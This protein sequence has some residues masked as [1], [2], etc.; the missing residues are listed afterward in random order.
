MHCISGHIVKKSDQELCFLIIENLSF[1]QKKKKHSKK[2]NPILKKNLLEHVVALNLEDQLSDI[3]DLNEKY[4]IFHEKM[5]Q[6]IN[7]NAPLKKMSKQRAK[8]K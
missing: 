1:C 3:Y 5:M 6:N 8:T 4:N 7:N 2:I